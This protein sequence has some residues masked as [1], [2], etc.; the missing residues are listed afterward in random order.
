MGCDA[1]ASGERRERRHL[2]QKLLFFVSCTFAIPVMNLVDD[3]N[4]IGNE[5]FT[6]L[7]Q[8]PVFGGGGRES[9]LRTVFHDGG[10]DSGGPVKG[11]GVLMRITMRISGADGR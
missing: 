1:Q 5:M 6:N 9:L 2:A 10:D 8:G 4:H 11:S 3:I 7:V